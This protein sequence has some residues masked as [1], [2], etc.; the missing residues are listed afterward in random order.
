M[1]VFPRLTTIQGMYDWLLLL[2]ILFAAA[3]GLLL[4]ASY[5]GVLPMIDSLDGGGAALLPAVGAFC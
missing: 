4:F 1:S 5:V 3:L 2:T